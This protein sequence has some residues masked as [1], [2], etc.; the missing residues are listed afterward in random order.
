MCLKPTTVDKMHDSI[1]AFDTAIRQPL[2]VPLDQAR[3]LYDILQ[4]FVVVYHE[5][6]NAYTL[7]EQVQEAAARG[8]IVA[9]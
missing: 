8:D 1:Y 5:I 6:Y 7:Q 9:R 3:R 2:S 4:Q